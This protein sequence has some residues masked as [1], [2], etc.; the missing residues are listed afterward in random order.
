MGGLRYH[1]NLAGLTHHAW[2][3]FAEHDGLVVPI[4]VPVEGITLAYLLQHFRPRSPTGEADAL[5]HLFF[6]QRVVAILL[7]AGWQNHAHR[8]DKWQRVTKTSNQPR[9]TRSAL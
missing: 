3:T 2:A 4:D 9:L 7:P 8:I 5:R 1:A 6:G